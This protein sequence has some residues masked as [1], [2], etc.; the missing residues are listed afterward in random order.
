MTSLIQQRIAIDRER[1]IG[2]VY[3]A[4]GSLML[5][6]GLVMAIIE[7]SQW[8]R[9]AFMVVWA[10]FAAVGVRKLAAARRTRRAFES[11]HGVDAGKQ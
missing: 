11:E 4:L 2:T 8:S 7:P 6:L 1:V 5:S 3:T 9:W 10:G